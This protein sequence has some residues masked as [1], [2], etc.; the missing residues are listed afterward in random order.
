MAPVVLNVYDLAPQNQWTIFCGVGIFHSG[1]EVHGVEYAYGQHDYDYS[2]IF[3]TNPRDAPGQVVFRESILMGETHL[4]QAE[5]HALVQRMGNDY[6]GTNYHLLQRNCNHFANDLCVQLIGKEAPTW[7]NRLA[8]I[9]VMLHCLIPPSWVPPLQT[10]S[11]APIDY[12]GHVAGG[13]G[14]VGGPRKDRDEGKSLLGA[15]GQRSD[16]YGERLNPSAMLPS[17]ASSSGGTRI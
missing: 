3:A 14:V 5:I 9:A 11:A 16:V 6:K 7:V 10:P 8:G 2:G 13:V 1:V 17:A 4:S 15:G 12:D